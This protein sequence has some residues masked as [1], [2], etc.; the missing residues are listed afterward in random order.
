MGEVVQSTRSRS[1]ACPPA[2]A[3]DHLAPSRRLQAEL[4]AVLESVPAG[5]LLLDLSGRIRYFNTAFV[6]LFGLEIAQARRA[7]HIDD[8]EAILKNHFRGATSLSFRWRASGDGELNPAVD[9]LEVLKPSS[10][11]IERASRPVEDDGRVTGW[12]E[13]YQDIT[14]RRHFQSNLLQTEKM[15]ALGQ[16]VSGIAHE[17]NNPLTAIMGYAQ[18]LLVQA[19]GAGTHGETKHIYQEA[20]RARR[21]VK[22]LL[23][24]ARENK[25]ERSRADLNE[26]VERTLA[27]RSYELRIENIVVKI[28]L[29]ADLPP[30]MADPHQLQQVLLNL[31][32]NAEQALLESRGSGHVHI[33][34]YQSAPQR[35]SVEISDDGPGIA[36][37]ISSRIFD[38]F[39]S[40]KPPGVGTGLGL[41]IVYGIVHQ[42]GGEVTFENRAE[43]GTRFIVELPIV[44]V[45]TS[46][47]EKHAGAEAYTAA[48]VNKG[49]IL[50]VEDEPTVARLIV[51]VLGD[52]GHQVEA[53][54]DSQE[55]LARLSR[56]RYDAVICDLRMPRLDG[57]AFYESL[58]RAGSPLSERVLFIT[59]DTLTPRT[60]DFLEPRHLPHLDKPFLVE[61][62]KIA[63]SRLLERDAPNPDGSSPPPGA[64]SSSR[65][66]E[67]LEHQ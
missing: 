31:I 57:Q 63:V 7:S 19:S 2:A 20:E 3:A 51:D 53:V 29:A 22:N 54:L 55:G 50:V 11:V 58:L 17:L 5:V 46:E 38:P 10:R 18:L 25:P 65:E 1:G 32:V 9:E 47:P 44:P 13:I 28:S 6:N 36:S 66:L 24:F 49:H 16:L 21:I 26:I 34:T 33:R 64:D 37:E 59:G 62:L 40:T 14:S 27:L 52:D 39:F 48:G 15:A 4:R 12:L 23:F 61:E 60:R 30:T 45:A 67:S 8:L 35:V 43:G 41:S 56:A 42:H